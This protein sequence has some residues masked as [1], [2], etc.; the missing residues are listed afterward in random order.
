MDKKLYITSDKN[1]Q[2]VTA[3]KS[4]RFFKI[5]LPPRMKDFKKLK[6]YVLK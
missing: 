3:V 5:I 1:T 2:E 6:K 4:L